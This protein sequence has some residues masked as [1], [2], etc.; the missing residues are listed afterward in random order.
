MLI[1]SLADIAEHNCQIKKRA[2]E[3]FFL[4]RANEHFFVSGHSN[5]R[6]DDMEIKMSPKQFPSGGYLM[7]M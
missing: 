2:D 7:A 1:R 6:V 5:E 3:N 4:K